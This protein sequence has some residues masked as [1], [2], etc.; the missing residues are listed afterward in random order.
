MLI[1]VAQ[2]TIY[3][4]DDVAEEV[5]RRAHD[6]HKSLSTFL[7]EIVEAYTRPPSWPDALVQLLTTGEGTLVEPDD[8]LPDDEEPIL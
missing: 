1:V 4:P 3:L 7:V 8:P 6:A 2:V 5:R